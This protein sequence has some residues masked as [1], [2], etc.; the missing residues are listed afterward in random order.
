LPVPRD[1]NHAYAAKDLVSSSSF[2][3]G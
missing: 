3:L 2:W 1:L